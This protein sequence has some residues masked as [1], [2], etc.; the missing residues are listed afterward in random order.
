MRAVSLTGINSMNF[1]A[2]ESKRI[3]LGSRW[4]GGT[5]HAEADVPARYGDGL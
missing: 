1:A 3:V 2:G 5:L 4:L